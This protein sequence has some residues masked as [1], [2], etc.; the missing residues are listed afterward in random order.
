MY[1]VQG[2]RLQDVVLSTQDL[3]MSGRRDPVAF[4]TVLFVPVSCGLRITMIR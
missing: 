1:R 4:E 3:E 2:F